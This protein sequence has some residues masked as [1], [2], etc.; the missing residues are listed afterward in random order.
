[1]SAKS[2]R[3]EPDAIGRWI[4]QARQGSRDAL[5]KSIEACRTYLLLIANQELDADLRAKGGP[6]DLVQET[7]LEAQRD[8]ARFEGR[9]E[10]ELLGWLRTIL[11]HNVANF[12]RKYRG[13]QMRTTGAEIS[14]D[15]SGARLD[16]PDDA[17][18]VGGPAI[19]DEQ[20]QLVH[21]AIDALPEADRQVVLWR[22]R[23]NLTFEEIGRRFGCP[24][25]AACKR[26]QRA[27]E[28][29]SWDLD[30]ADPNTG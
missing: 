1:M 8:F 3:N 20:A 30:R 14:L 7:F 2:T 9:S 27:I 25:P 18:S 11:L 29:L 26:W 5:G 16:P 12:V 10:A 28:R 6:S 23:D 4:E 21:A 13:T 19:R 22:H 15:A 17:T 24:A